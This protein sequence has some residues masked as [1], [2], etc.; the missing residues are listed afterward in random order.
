MKKIALF[1]SLLLLNGCFMY[2]NFDCALRGTCEDVE[3]AENKIYTDMS[4]T[5]ANRCTK[6]RGLKVGTI[7][8]MDCN[9]DLR[10]MFNILKS[11]YGIEDARDK[12]ISK[13]AAHENICVGYGMKQGTETFSKCLAKLEAKDAAIAAR[14][15][16]LER[17]RRQAG[18]EALAQGLNDTA[19]NLD[20]SPT[21]RCSSHRIGNTT[22]TDC[23]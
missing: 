7:E 19:N 18:I 15:V 9:E 8:F 5:I 12:F 1:S 22:Y 10:S 6:E 20:P 13:L 4:E 11:E 14:Q 21:V 2:Q 17:Q 16:E 23:H 3:A